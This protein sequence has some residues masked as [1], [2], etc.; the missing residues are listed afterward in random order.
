MQF[1]FSI[2]SILL[3]KS[4]IS[5]STSIVDLKNINA[6]KNSKK[7]I[8][9]AKSVNDVCYIFELTKVVE[10]IPE[11]LPE[12]SASTSAIKTPKSDS[13]PRKR[14]RLA[15]EKNQQEPG[16]GIYNDETQKQTYMIA[17]YELKIDKIFENIKAASLN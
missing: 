5:C 16:F 11:V 12:V 9:D 13:R 17:S 4:N 2:L 8:P 10:T 1:L 14:K 3:I 6:T 7:D 15:V